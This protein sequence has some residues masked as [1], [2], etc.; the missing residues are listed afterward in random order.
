MRATAPGVLEP[1]RRLRAPAN[2]GNAILTEFLVLVILV[3]ANGILA[4]AEI[5]V[6]ALRKTRV[7]Q[8]VHEG[9]SAARAVKRLQ[10]DP[11]RFLA[12]V[13]I[14]ITVVGAT[15]GVFGGS[16]VARDLEPL[17]V[18]IPLLAPYAGEIAL[19]V[20]V[21][22]VS[23]LSLVLGELVPKSLALR[24]SERY[25]LLIGRPLVA[26]SW[27]ARPFVWILTASS[28]VVLRLF[29]DRTTFTETRLSPEE[30]QQLVGEATEA[31]S[32]DPTAG[33]IA[34]RAIEFGDLTAA[35]VMIPRS[36]VIAIPRHAKPDEVQRILLEQ[37]HTRMPI[38][39]GAPENVIGYVTMK[40][41]MAL[42]LEQQLIV[43]EDAL[44]PPYFVP[45]AMRAVELLSEMRARRMQLAIV[46]DEGGAMSGIVALEDLVEELVGEIFSE[47]DVGAVEAIRLE[48]GGT[49]LVRAD[50]PIREVIRALGI[51][52]PE[53]G[54][55]S[56]L[57][58]LCLALAGRIPREGERFAAPDGTVLEIVDASPRQVRSIRVIPPVKREKEEE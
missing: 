16:R 28:N 17:V 49:A 22:L 25:A 36:R 50:T 26:L 46:V 48:P 7:E 4:G 2:G 11:E 31:G 41:L 58:G 32:V 39:E 9:R 47:H 38:Y 52:L 35:D 33:E 18:E 20:V 56:T 40:D 19:G 37:G 23:F 44:R 54:D 34:S 51:E 14:G 1:A 10:E 55:W 8:L 6:V 53:E 21:V 29:G 13:Q 42:F 3:L 12:T 43:L 5:A 15:A 45:E 27:I 30:L 57:A 24:A